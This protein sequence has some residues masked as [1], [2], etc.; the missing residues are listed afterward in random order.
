MLFMVEIKPVI[1][2]HLDEARVKELLAA[3][4]EAAL[5]YQKEGS[6]LH[7][8]RTSGRRNA[9]TIWDV[10]SNEVLHEKVSGLPLFPYLET[11]VTPLSPHPSAA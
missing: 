4:R 6:L 8:W 9:I 10:A 2:H 1:P 5:A 3:E 7:L 11:I